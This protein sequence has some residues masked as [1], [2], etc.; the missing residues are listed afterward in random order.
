MQMTGERRIAA[1]R[2][3]VWAALNDPQ[4][5]KACIPGCQSLEKTD[6]T[7]MSAIATIR[8][9]P[10]S[11]RFTGDVTLSDLDPPNGYRITGE[12]QG[13]AAGFAKGGA[14][15]RLS[16]EG[17]G[18][19]LAYEVDAQ[20]GGR[21]SQ[22]GG[23]LIDATAKQMADL[24]F[25]KFAQAVEAPPVQ[26]SA[27]EATEIAPVRAAPPAL[28]ARPAVAG[29][30]WFGLAALAAGAAAGYLAGRAATGWDGQGAGAGLAVG[31][32]VVLTAGAAF[33]F[34]RRSATPAAPLV[35]LAAEMLPRLLA[36]AGRTARGG[37]P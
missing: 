28:V 11:A 14:R 32:L 29:G 19:L 16:S 3:A 1:R 12:G 26:A 35:V 31:L 21:L 20:V 34:G 23:G 25:K 18:T 2:E 15:V 6:E 30:I 17:D 37:A 5:L 9:G 10:I 13:G 4:V 8:V 27:P 7:H 24:F 22:L 33:G 36:A